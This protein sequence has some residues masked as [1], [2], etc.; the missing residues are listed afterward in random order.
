MRFEKIAQGGAAESYEAGTVSWSSDGAE[1]VTMVRDEQKVE[2][3]ALAARRSTKNGVERARTTTR[4]SPEE[5]GNE[6]SGKLLKL[7]GW[8]WL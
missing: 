8:S 4:G 2:V 6:K 5:V 7:E 3:V 1:N